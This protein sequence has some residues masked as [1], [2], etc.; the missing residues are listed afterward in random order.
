MQ[1]VLHRRRALGNVTQVSRSTPPRRCLQRLAWVKERESEAD[2]AKAER[3]RERLAMMLV[4]W[5]DFAVVRTI[6]FDDSE[7]VYALG[8]PVTKQM[9]IQMNK[10]ADARGAERTLCHGPAGAVWRP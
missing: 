8:K 1:L 10:A 2:E 9:V 3:E 6:D 4:D 5:H 7:D